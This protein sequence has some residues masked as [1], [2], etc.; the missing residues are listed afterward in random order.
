VL[1]SKR[2]GADREKWLV[3]EK[4]VSDNNT[5]TWQVH[6]EKADI[7]RTAEPVARLPVKTLFTGDQLFENMVKSCKACRLLNLHRLYLLIQQR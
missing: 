1:T 3:P 6:T 4:P 7:H 5:D 2:V